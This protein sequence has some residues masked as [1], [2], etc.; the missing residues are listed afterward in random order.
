MMD[1]VISYL[2]FLG[3]LVVLG[4]FLWG[5]H[6]FLIGRHP[7][8]GNERKFPRQLVLLESVILF[9]L[10]NTLAAFLNAGCSIRKYKRRSGNWSRFPTLI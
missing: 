2:P 8:M 4:A 10:A 5:M 9:A 1:L 3:V 6:W 7:D